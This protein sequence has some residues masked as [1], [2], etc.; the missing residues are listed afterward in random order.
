MD[1][2]TR[3]GWNWDGWW[4][5]SDPCVLCAM[6]IIALSGDRDII[7]PCTALLTTTTALTKGRRMATIMIAKTPQAE[8]RCILK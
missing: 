2:W 8:E 1:G 7:P 6:S 4:W 5:W 3:G